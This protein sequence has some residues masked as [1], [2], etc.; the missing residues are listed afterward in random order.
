MLSVWVK[1]GV[2]FL[3]IATAGGMAYAAGVHVGVPSALKSRGKGL[4]ETIKAPAMPSGPTAGVPGTSYR[5]TTGGSTS[6]LSHAVE[7][8]FNWGDGTYSSWGIGTSASH[9]WTAAGT[10][11]VRAEARCATHT[12][13]TSVSP[14]LTVSVVV[15]LSGMVLIPAGDFN[16]GSNTYGDEQPVHVVRLDAYYIDKY[17]VTFDQYDAFCDATGRVKPD[18]SGWSRGTR[19]VV[20]IDWNDA[21]AYC[22]WAGKR[23]PTEAEWERACRAGTDTAY[24]FGDDAG[25]VGSYA[26]YGSNSGSMTHPVGEKLPN[27]FGLYDMHGNVWEW[28]ADWYG[29]GYYAVSPANN[30]Q[31][32]ASGTYRVLRGGSWFDNGVLPRSANRS[33]VLGVPGTR[34]SNIG[35]RCACLP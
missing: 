3:A 4:A 17:E 24:S 12:T 7:Y 10:Y 21:K 35:C 22:E 14:G 5:Y 31:G 32:P 6:S 8:R 34:A 11:T 9:T 1:R 13:V 30:P 33:D 23:L 2:C 29:S 28:C 15:S 19:P 16:M 18:D 26:W 25:L 27:A 20:N